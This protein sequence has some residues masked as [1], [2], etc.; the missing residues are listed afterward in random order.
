MI[1]I[2]RNIKDYEGL[3]QVSNC[4]RVKRLSN[5][6]QMKEKILRSVKH[7]RGYLKIGL[8]KNGSQ[9]DYFIHRLVAQ[10][11]IINPIN[12]PEVNHRDENKHNNNISNLEW[13]SS[14]YNANYGTRNERCHLYKDKNIILASY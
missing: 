13:C 14:K 9:K 3:Y 1:E 11:F 5:N 8:H 10:A 2:W 4:G 12:L 6:R 7:G